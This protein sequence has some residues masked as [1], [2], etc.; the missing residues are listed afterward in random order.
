[1]RNVLAGFSFGDGINGS[2]FTEFF[3]GHAYDSP[4]QF[5]VFSEYLATGLYLIWQN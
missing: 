3:L 5:T 4:L 2:G 1:M